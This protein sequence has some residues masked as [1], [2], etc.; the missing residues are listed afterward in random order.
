MVVILYYKMMGYTPLVGY[1]VLMFDKIPSTQ[2]YAHGVIERGKATNRL[3]ICA[4]AQS[5]GYGRHN[6]TWVSHHGNL[7]TSIIYE[8][9]IRRPQIAYSVAVAIAKTLLSVGIKPQI[10]W[11]N[12]ILIEGKK[13]CG[14]LIEFIDNFVVIGIGINIKSNPTVTGYKTTKLEN[15]I[16]ITT[17]ELLSRLLKNMDI[18]LPTDFENV[19]TRWME[20]AIGI[21]KNVEYR[22]ENFK[23]VGIDANGAIVL[24]RD[25]VTHH[26]YGDEIRIPYLQNK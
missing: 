7:Y 12:D 23:F 19:R 26:V 9:P 1:K 5:A 4:M 3:V 18:W 8:A 14:V 11:P 6:R 10:K 22:G 20:L 2:T 21:N 24:E 13:V 17:E 16:N 15:Y 25:N